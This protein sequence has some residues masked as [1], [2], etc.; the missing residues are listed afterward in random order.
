MICL[1]SASKYGPQLT[2]TPL[3]RPLVN[4][5]SIRPGWV[6]QSRVCSAWALVCFADMVTLGFIT[7]M[8]TCHLGGA[9]PTASITLVMTQQLLFEAKVLV[10]R[11]KAI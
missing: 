11:L 8:E 3:T 6:L 9:M 2:P 1:L 10:R 5:L 4:V 7:G